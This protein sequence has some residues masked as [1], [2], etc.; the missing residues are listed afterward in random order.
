MVVD[1]ARDYAVV[2]VISALEADG[3]RHH[4]LYG[5]EDIHSGLAQA[6]I[7]L[8]IE[9]L[10]L[11]EDEGAQLVRFVLAQIDVQVFHGLVFV[12]KQQLQQFHA[13]QSTHVHDRR[14]LHF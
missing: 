11:A 2:Q 10:V 8:E 14:F 5:V 6:E 13:V 7:L 3:R 9:V 12:D 1:F 4:V